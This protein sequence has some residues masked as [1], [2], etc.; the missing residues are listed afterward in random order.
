MQ[1][2]HLHIDQKQ[3]A[4]ICCSTYGSL[5]QFNYGIVGFNNDNNRNILLT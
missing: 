4:V 3:C 5:K 2:S 1:I